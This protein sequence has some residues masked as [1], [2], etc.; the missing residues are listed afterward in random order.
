MLMVAPL[1]DAMSSKAGAPKKKKGLIL[2]AFAVVREIS[3]L[4]AR[5][6]A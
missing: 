2:P 5:G 3:P 4:L 1:F 6:S